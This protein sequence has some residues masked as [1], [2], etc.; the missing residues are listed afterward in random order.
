[1]TL[2]RIKH[3][4]VALARAE[5]ARTDYHAL[6][7]ARVVSMGEDNTV[8]IKPDSAR[9]GAGLSMVKIKHGLP[10]VSVRVKPGARVLLGF[11]EG[12]SKR[13]YVALWEPGSLESLT[14]EASV[15]LLLKAPNVIAAKTKS[16]AKR[17]ARMG[18]LV[19]VTGV[20]G[21]PGSPLELVGYILDGAQNLTSE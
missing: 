7:P 18:D 2:D 21:P 12:D 13:P 14:I 4:L 3:W 17:V 20:C 1:M 19:K 8:D 16:N 11:E 9:W 15:E 5:V 10:G 6:Y